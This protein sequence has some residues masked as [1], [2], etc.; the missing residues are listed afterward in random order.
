MLRG[1]TLD[2][3]A[4]NQIQTDENQGDDDDENDNYCYDDYH[5]E[6]R[7][8]SWDEELCEMYF[9]GDVLP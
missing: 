6:A 5:C 3:A 2:K 7:V 9:F 4:K 1:V 8:C